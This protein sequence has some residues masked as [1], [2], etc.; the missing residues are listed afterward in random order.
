MIVQE[1]SVIAFIRDGRVL[2][3]RVFAVHD[4]ACSV[5]VSA[6]RA[7]CVE[8]WEILL[9]LGIDEAYLEWLMSEEHVAEEV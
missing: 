5:E 1:G 9:V 4:G 2:E 8:R 6:H 3:G 7:Y